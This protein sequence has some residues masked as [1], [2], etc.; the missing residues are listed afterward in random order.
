MREQGR[1]FRPQG[2]VTY[3][4]IQY[5]LDN[6]LLQKR[7]I[8]KMVGVSGSVVSRQAKGAYPSRSEHKIAVHHE[9]QLK[10]YE[11]HMY[12]VLHENFVFTS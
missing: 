11:E 7:L 10:E 4:L 6:T 9:R 8:A 1:Y 5:L 12:K 3:L 2:L